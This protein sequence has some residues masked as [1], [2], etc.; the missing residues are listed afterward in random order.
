MGALIVN[1]ALQTG[2]GEGERVEC[3]GEVIGAVCEGAAE[4]VF[5][6]ISKLAGD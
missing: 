5:D 4:V 6:A 1:V 2:Y 3:K